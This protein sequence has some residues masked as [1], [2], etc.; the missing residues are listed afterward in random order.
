MIYSLQYGH[1][2]A[3]ESYINYE[4]YWLTNGEILP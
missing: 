2:Q 4:I 3:V 1:F